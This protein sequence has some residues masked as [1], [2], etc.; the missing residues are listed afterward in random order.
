MRDN[1]DAFEW[2]G[3]VYDTK[4]G[5]MVTA[6]DGKYTYRF[7]ATLWNEGPNQ[8]QTADFPVEVDTQAP[9]L[10]VKYD[11]AS[12]TLSGNYGRCRCLDLQII[13]MQ[14]LR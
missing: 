11:A 3:K 1:P 10:N 14:Q 6:P 2:D 8:K 13:H 7:V 12:H 4:T 5:Q 9:N